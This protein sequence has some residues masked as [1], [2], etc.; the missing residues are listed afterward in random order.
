MVAITAT[1][2]K[3]GFQKIQKSKGRGHK[4][5]ETWML[6][7]K[8]GFISYHQLKKSLKQLMSSVVLG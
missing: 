4:G 5:K 8:L 2:P 6:Y 7:N 1:C 3:L